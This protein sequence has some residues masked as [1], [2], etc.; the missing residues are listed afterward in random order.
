MVRDVQRMCESV[1]RVLRR[2]GLCLQISFAQP[3][4]RTKYLSGERHCLLL[5]AEESGEEDEGAGMVAAP[6]S[7][8]AGRSQC[9]SYDWVLSH[10]TL[11][12]SGGCLDCFL[13]CMR[14]VEDEG[15]G[16]SSPNDI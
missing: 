3:H 7:A 16:S 15:E 4:F 12:A 14:M 6:Y 2:G 5:Q 1:A 8:S 9:R 10:S 13:Y 11:P